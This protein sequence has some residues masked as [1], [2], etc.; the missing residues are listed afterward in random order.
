MGQVRVIAST[1]FLTCTAK[2]RLRSVELSRLIQQNNQEQ[3]I[4]IEDI[5]GT[6]F[7]RY[8]QGNRLQGGMAFS[9]V[10][11]CPLLLPINGVSA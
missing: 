8:D 5:G 9:T 6:A 2:P 1:G 11:K 3:E 7:T 10:E 4:T